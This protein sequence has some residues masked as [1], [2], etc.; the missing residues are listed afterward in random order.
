MSMPAYRFL[1]VRTNLEGICSA[2]M[3]YRTMSRR[4]TSTR[5]RPPCCLQPPLYVRPLCCCLRVN[6]AK[7]SIL[8]LDGTSDKSPSI[9][10]AAVYFST[11]MKVGPL[12][13]LRLP[14]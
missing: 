14:K 4:T 9:I 2:T 13:W 10:I 11:D 6:E 8:M 1:L 3:T 5:Y 12:L 7:P